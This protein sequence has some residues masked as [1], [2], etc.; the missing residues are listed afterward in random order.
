M[1]KGLWK[2]NFRN[3]FYIFT[4]YTYWLGNFINWEKSHKN[5]TINFRNNRSKIFFEIKIIISIT[6]PVWQA[7]YKWIQIRIIRSSQ[8]L[9][10]IILVRY[11][12]SYLVLL[13]KVAWVY[14]IRKY[15][16]SFN[17]SFCFIRFQMRHI[18]TATS[19]FYFCLY[20]KIYKCSNYADDL[21]CSDGGD[22]GKRGLERVHQAG[23]IGK[24]TRLL[25]TRVESQW[26][27]S[28]VKGSKHFR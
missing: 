7:G 6:I 14:D 1:H 4:V 12:K 3:F 10:A 17:I 15:L 25:R 20:F 11:F 23:F 27:S 8:E 13:N 28:R 26:R 18:N 24:A 19:F 5:D 2:Y 21:W 22:L 9:S 16:K